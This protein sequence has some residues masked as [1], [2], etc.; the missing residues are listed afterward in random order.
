MLSDWMTRIVCTIGPA[1]VKPGVLGKMIRAGMNVARLNFSHGEFASHE[2]AIRLIRQASSEVGKPVAIM[3]DL[4]GPKLRVGQVPNGPALLE[5]DAPFVLTTEEV[6]GNAERVTVDFPSLTAVIK[7]GDR[8]SINDGLIQLEVQEVVG[9]EIR[10]KV[11]VGGELSS[12]KGLNL[13]GIDLGMSAF[14]SRDRECLAFALAAGVDAVSQS[15][16]AAASDVEEVRAAAAELGHEVFIIAKIER[17]GALV[18]LDAILDASDGIMVAR[19]DLGVEIP[20]EEIAVTQKR[21]VEQANAFGKP[22]IT[23]THMLESM[24]NYRRPTRAEA[25]DVANAILDGTDAV[26]L[27]GESAVGKYPVDAVRMLASIAKSTEP[28]RPEYRAR[29]SWDSLALAREPEAVDVVA[30]GVQEA[31]ERAKPVAIV[32]P[33]MSGRTA[34]N[35]T[36][37]RLPVWI[38]AVSPSQSTCRQLLFS[39]GVRTILTDEHPG[40][41]NPHIR[42][43][44]KAAG[45][46]PGMVI[47]TEGPSSANPDANHRMEVLDFRGGW[48]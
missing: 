26:M 23:A 3:A 30:R 37:F 7:P 20:I 16:V 10:C 34:R 27:S 19:G 38:T 29:V 36:R 28:H 24:V 5:D 44:L 11:L 18:N 42:K 8:P 32:V 25:T 33:T 45:V 1:S 2:E 48:G 40:N 15:F 9:S 46:P 17:A 13:P 31:V 21:L 35:V 22:V 14:T 47:L 6:E 12:R 39:Y 43:Y 4:S 41:W